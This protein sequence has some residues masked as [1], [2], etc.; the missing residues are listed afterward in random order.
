M[1]EEEEEEE[2]EDGVVWGEACWKDCVSSGIVL[3]LVHIN[4]PFKS[5]MELNGL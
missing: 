5:L 2:E 4:T 1:E 3:F